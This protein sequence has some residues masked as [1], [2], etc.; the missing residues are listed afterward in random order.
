MQVDGGHVAAN[1][2][3]FLNG[4]SNENFYVITFRHSICRTVSKLAS[5]IHLQ[6]AEVELI[7]KTLEWI[8]MDS[9]WKK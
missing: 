2:A 3:T 1:C 4:V 7:E 6:P 8:G 5:T 9:S